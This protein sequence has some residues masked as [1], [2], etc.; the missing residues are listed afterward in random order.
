M[1]TKVKAGVAATAAAAI[2]AGGST[3]A[4][5]S[6]TAELNG[7][8]ITNGTL[9]VAVSQPQWYDISGDRTDK[10]DIPA[11]P[12]TQGHAITL[13]EFKGVPGDTIAGVFE[14]DGALAGDNMVAGLTFDNPVMAQFADAGGDGLGAQAVDI[15][16]EGW[17]VSYTVLD[18]SGAVVG[19]ADRATL[20]GDS[21]LFAS[22][23]NSHNVTELPTMD[24]AITPGNPD[25]R[26]VVKATFDPATGGTTGAGS[27][28]GFDGFQV[29]LTQSRTSGGL[30][31]F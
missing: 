12:G 13:D 20:V 19:E 15:V 9:D 14:L 29:G 17:T 22:K 31:G 25:Y 10:T 3:F 4:L 23:D 8:G 16:P 24:D 21:M 6:K 7:G 2:L 27:G 28:S 18:R 11:L 5:W 26:V 30:G 1:N